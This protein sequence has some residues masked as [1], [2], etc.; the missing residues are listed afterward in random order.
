M[1]TWNAIN[2]PLNVPLP[3]ETAHVAVV[4]R[5]DD[6]RPSKL[7]VGG[8]LRVGVPILDRA[9]HHIGQVDGEGFVRWGEVSI[10]GEPKLDRRQE[11][12][13]IARA[14]LDVDRGHV[15]AQLDSDGTVRA[16]R[17]GQRPRR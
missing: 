15:A 3:A 16:I 8:R 5:T 12:S 6:G 13:A 11:S 1:N 7:A 17:L 2:K 10:A 4:Y 9:G 14:A